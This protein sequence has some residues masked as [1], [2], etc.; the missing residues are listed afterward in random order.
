MVQDFWKGGYKYFTIDLDDGEARMCLSPAKSSRINL[1]PYG[2]EIHPYRKAY[3]VDFIK[4]SP[5]YRNKGHGTTLLKA[6]IKWANISK[7]VIILD[8]IPIDSGMNQ[9]RLVRFYSTHGFKLSPYKDNKYSM[10]YHN[11]TKPMKATNVKKFVSDKCKGYGVRFT[12][13]R[14]QNVILGELECSGYFDDSVPE[15]AIAVGKP[16]NEYIP[17]LIHEFNHMEQWKEQCPA[18]VNLGDSCEILDEWLAGEE[19]TSDEVNNAINRIIDVEFDCERRSVAF[20]EEHGIDINTTEYIQ[21]SNAYVLFYNTIRSTRKWYN[22]ERKP[23]MIKEV[24]NA[25][26]KEFSDDNYKLTTEQHKAFAL[27]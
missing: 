26:P 17:V 6:A 12:L 7:N 21:K 19:F 10:Y 24:W 14:G 11:R 5:K 20:I 27:L 23:Y 9:H 2:V 15:L 25:M 1:V 3:Y 8:A 4:V 16:A 22:S 18:W 13:G